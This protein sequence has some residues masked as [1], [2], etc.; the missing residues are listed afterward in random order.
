MTY[1]AQQIYVGTSEADAAKFAAETFAIKRPLEEAKEE[2]EK[3]KDE[4]DGAIKL[5]PAPDMKADPVGW[6]QWHV[7]DF[8]DVAISDPVRAFKT[9]PV[10]GAGIAAG[11]ATALAIL[12][13][14]EFLV[15]S[16]G[17]ATAVADLWLPL[18]PVFSF[19]LPSK[20]QVKQT[21]AAVA[22]KT[23]AVTA[24]I[25]DAADSI[26]DAPVAE[27]VDEVKEGV[28]TRAGKAA[29]KTKDAVAEDK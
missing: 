24:D 18:G 2:A 21:K 7:Q 22:K 3:P 15:K 8:M 14:G 20:K 5:G 4:A 26:K 10:Q 28:R 23:D 6:A 13:A 29:A 11:F 25:K 9:K 1:V 19:I 12:T 27:K 16:C 17:R